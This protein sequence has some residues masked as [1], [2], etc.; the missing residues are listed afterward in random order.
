MDSIPHLTEVVKLMLTVQQRL[1]NASKELFRLATAKA[2]AEREYRI[3][4]SKQILILKSEG[5]P[6]TLISDI[7]R[8]LTADKK[9]ERDKADSMFAAARDSVSALQT[10]AS[11]LKSIYERQ[12]EV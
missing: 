12:T 3:E 1:A 10:E 7:A 8:G 4:L 11:L 2:E 9:F 6:A 5:K